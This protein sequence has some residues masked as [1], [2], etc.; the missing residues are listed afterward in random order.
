MC[1]IVGYVGE[2]S[3][4][5]ILIEGLERLEYRGYDSAGIAVET[6]DGLSVVKTKGKVA[7]LRA[8]DLPSAD[9]GTGI[10]HTRWA[11]HGEPSDVNAHPHTDGSGRIAV[12]HNGIIENAT[13]IRE[14]LEEQGAKFA[15]DTDSEVIAHLVATAGT[16]DLADAVR[17]ALAVVEGTYG[18]AVI[19]RTQP[20]CIVVAR[21][22]SPVVLGLGNGEN[23]VASDIAAIVRHTQQAVFLE[24]GEMAVVRADS[25]RTFW[26]D[27]TET[28]RRAET[29]S[30]GF[31]TYEKGEHSHFMR[32]EIYEQP[33]AVRRTF[34]GRL[35]RRAS[36]A[37][38]GGIALEPRDILRLR[39]VRIL[40]CGSA[41]YAS[42]SGA[43]LIEQ[44]ARIPA[45]AEP[46]SEFRYRNPIIEPD[47]LYVA[48]SQS[49]ET[50]D[51][52]RAVQ[53][54]KRKGGQV[55][56]VV[57]V[58]GSTIARECDAGIYLHA[59]PE[60]SVASTKAF[61]CTVAALALL[62]LHLGRVRD[63]G[64]ADGDRIID[65]MDALPELIADLLSIEDHVADVA[66]RFAV[67]T[68]AMFVGR[69]NGFPVALEGAQKLK[70]VSYVHAEAYPSA[71]LK[72]GPLALIG[73]DVPSVVVAPD[74]HLFEKNLSTIAEIRSRRGPVIAVGHTESLATVADDVL[75]VPKSEPELDPLLLGIPLQLL[76]FHAALLRGVDIDQP[77]N[78]AKSVTVE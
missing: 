75:L 59:G 61:T 40:G 38:L 62:A 13:S 29:I 5:P 45:E 41:Y 4:V 49:G 48:V 64:T 60:I 77:R 42:R 47:T 35:D 12:V 8:M 1:G 16:D 69:V 44:L 34:S 2:R 15:S 50:L 3:S 36:T 7:T 78:L 28:T 23:F 53:E 32:K 65:G 52:L 30:W 55:L 14:R 54:V 37:H 67:A 18:I 56:G 72:H 11:T 17:K 33:E 27:S 39:R 51:T 76:A 68:S 9:L 66:Q 22:G 73:P 63:L 57:N 24:D 74:D 6:G 46:A 25:I 58:V 31:D 19:D 10:G 20:G 26:L 43:S 70:E 71:E 21:N